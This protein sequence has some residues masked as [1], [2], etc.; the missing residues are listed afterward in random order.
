LDREHC[1]RLPRVS[2]G[3]TKQNNK[4]EEMLTLSLAN[5]PDIVCSR[6]NEQGRSE[7]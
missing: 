5:F 2:K 4:K 1:L 6:E 3:K 7:I